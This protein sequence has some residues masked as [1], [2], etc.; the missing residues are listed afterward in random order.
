MFT[1]PWHFLKGVFKADSPILKTGFWAVKLTGFSI[2][3][4]NLIEKESRINNKPHSTK[5]FDGKGPVYEDLGQAFTV[6]MHQWCI[7][8]G[9]CLA[10]PRDDPSICSSGGILKPFDKIRPV[11]FQCLFT[12]GISKILVC[13]SPSISSSALP[14]EVLLPSAANQCLHI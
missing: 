5:V 8:W 6:H 12:N 3:K 14:I 1:A 10:F 7:A 2:G 9:L 13:T 11:R 4:V